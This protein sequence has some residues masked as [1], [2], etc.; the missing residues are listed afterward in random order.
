MILFSSLRT[1]NENG[2]PQCVL[3]VLICGSRTSDGLYI[4][5]S[6][7]TFFWNKESI[8]IK[9]IGKNMDFGL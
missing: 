5:V 2:D 6:S 9:N 3:L 7:T 4:L 1:R 8:K